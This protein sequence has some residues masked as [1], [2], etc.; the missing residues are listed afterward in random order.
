MEYVL[1]R[2]HT[3]TLLQQYF[4]RLCR[5]KGNANHS[6]KAR[7]QDVPLV[8][9]SEHWGDGSVLAVRPT[10][11]SCTLLTRP[12]SIIPETK[13]RSLEEMDIIFGAV[14]AEER[15]ENIARQEQGGCRPA[16]YYAFPH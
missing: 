2:I 8:R 5:G 9:I 10:L 13:G 14:S 6:Y 12:N 7:L 11:L 1:S 3:S 4:P 15:A 16:S